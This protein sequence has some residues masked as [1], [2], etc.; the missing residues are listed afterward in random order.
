MADAHKN[1]AYSAV[2]TAP[3][4][5]SSG[6]SLVVTASDGAKFPAVPFNATIWPAGVQPL[7]ENAEIV[8][9]TGI[10][11]DT[12]TITRS[13]ESSNARSIVVGDQIAAT[14]TAKTLTDIETA[15]LPLTGSILPYASRV[16]PTGYLNC[17]G[18]AVSRSTYA[19]L[20]AVLARSLSTVT[21]T[22]A[23][24]AVVT[25]TAHGL[26]TGDAIYLTTTG[27]LPTG[28]SANTLYYIVRVDAN[29]YNLA[30]SRANAYAA[31]KIATSGSQSGTHTA[32]DCPYGL[33]DGSTTFTLPDF[34]GRTPAGMDTTG[35]SAASRLTLAETQGVYG[36]L[37]AAG[38]EQGH[39][40]TGA[41][42]G[43]SVHS[44]ANTVAIGTLA[45]SDPGHLH[46]NYAN[47]DA[48]VGGSSAR[49]RSTSGTGD[50]NGRTATTGVTLTGAPSISN[51]NSSAA[52][53]SSEHNVVQPVQLVNYI[54]AT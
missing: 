8:R 46:N 29:S 47:L 17:D 32:W 3:S 18:S 6:T 16:A 49:V 24:P 4:P 31:T 25:N 14:V 45:T 48:A 52:N 9:V 35:G 20:F 26:S 15:L 42:S 1:F 33:G 40:L 19:A 53:A 38:G 50:F 5:A 10:S 41:E 7:T 51:V 36:N 37:G 23:T 39:T 43:T 44:H 12:F 27:A 54:I 28:L 21:C 13:Q 11:T 22:I 30:S 34:R 2:A